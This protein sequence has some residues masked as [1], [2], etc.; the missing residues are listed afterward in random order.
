M[1]RSG[2]MVR[3]KSAVLD[4]LSIAPSSTSAAPFLPGTPSRS[5][6]QGFVTSSIGLEAQLLSASPIQPEDREAD[7]TP[8]NVLIP[9]GGLTIDKKHRC[10]KPLINIVGRPIIFWILDHLRLGRHDTLWLAVPE[11]IDKAFALSKQLRDEFPTLQLHVVH[12]LYP[13]SGER[14]SIPFMKLSICPHDPPTLRPSVRRLFLRLRVLAPP[15]TARDSDSDSAYV[16]WDDLLTRT[17]VPS[18][19]GVAHVHSHVPF[20]VWTSCRPPRDPLH[21][22]SIHG[23]RYP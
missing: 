9:M 17:G 1:E 14:P 22:P 18:K 20:L 13:T 11:D 7:L 3:S 5:A 6:S 21:H 2:G 15:H 16:V 12:L 23:A 10:P 4:G 8:L 19:P